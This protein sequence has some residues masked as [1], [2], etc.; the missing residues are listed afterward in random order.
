M[1]CLRCVGYL[2]ATELISEEGTI[3]AE[4]CVNCGWIGGEATIDTHHALEHPPEPGPQATQP[5]W[6]PERL[7][8]R[9][10]IETLGT[11]PFSPSRPDDSRLAETEEL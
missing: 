3:Y 4:R 7:R 8:L 5:V 10:T 2:V 6:D 1:S 9:V 11:G